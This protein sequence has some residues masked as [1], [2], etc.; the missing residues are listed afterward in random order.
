MGSNWDGSDDQYDESYDWDPE[1]YLSGEMEFSGPDED[2]IEAAMEA[3]CSCED[4]NSGSEECG[5]RSDCSEC[6]CTFKS[7]SF[8]D[9]LE[10]HCHQDDGCQNCECYDELSEQ[11]ATELGA[12]V[13][14][15]KVFSEIV[16]ALF[17]NQPQKLNW[18]IVEDTQLVSQYAA[19]VEF[20]EMSVAIG[21]P[22]NELKLRLLF[23]CFQ[24]K[25]INLKA[26]KGNNSGKK[27]SI[28][29]EAA[30][31]MRHRSGA[32]LESLAILHQRSLGAIAARLVSLRLAIPIDLERLYRAD[33]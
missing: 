3:T 12:H 2:D 32:S 29:E 21:V 20:G 14:D 8:C 33:K 30:L 25:G 24:A 11:D 7:C 23:L 6:D 27:W 26:S 15:S 5:H 1:N 17:N 4:E 28:D 19:D 13:P 9:C 18:S 16:S 31:R 22:V 10:D